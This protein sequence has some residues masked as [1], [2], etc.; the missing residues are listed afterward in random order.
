[1]LENAITTQQTK[2]MLFHQSKSFTS[3]RELFFHC[4]ELN[5]VPQKGWK[6]AP[7]ISLQQYEVGILISLN[8]RKLESFLQGGS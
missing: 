5:S 8:Q 1:M 3:K 6:I 4:W 7:Q 2:K